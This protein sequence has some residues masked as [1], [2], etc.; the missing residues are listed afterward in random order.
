MAAKLLSPSPHRLSPPYPSLPSKFTAVELAQHQWPR[1]TTRRARRL[2]VADA[3]TELSPLVSDNTQSLLL[4]SEATGYS[5]ASY[6]TSLG[7]FVI[8]VPGLWSL[9]KRSVKSKV[10]FFCRK[11]WAC[12]YKLITL[13][14]AEGTRFRLWRKRS[15]LK[16]KRWRHPI[17]SPEQSCPSS[18]V[19]TSRWRIEER[20]SRKPPPLSPRIMEMNFLYFTSTL[21]SNRFLQTH[22]QASIV[23]QFFLQNLADCPS[24]HHSNP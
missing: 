23:L 16:G 19:T 10:I 21:N 13:A 15:S 6:Y 7:L 11:R 18:L 4:L 1:S 24:S 20:Q 14:D 5:L 8:S 3:M 2:V 9:I 22:H 17:E 12:L